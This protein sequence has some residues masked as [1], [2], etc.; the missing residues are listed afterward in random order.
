MVENGDGKPAAHQLEPVEIRKRVAI[1]TNPKSGRCTLAVTAVNAC[2]RSEVGQG[3]V[4]PCRHER[5]SPPTV[6]AVT[7]VRGRS[8]DS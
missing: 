6:T 4:R 7:A 2:Q 5:G 1:Y 3:R 8:P